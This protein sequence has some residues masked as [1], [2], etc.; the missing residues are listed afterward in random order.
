M[1]PILMSPT[2]DGVGASLFRL[3][4]GAGVSRKRGGGKGEEDVAVPQACKDLPGEDGLRALEE[5]PAIIPKGCTAAAAAAAAA[6]VF[7]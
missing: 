7:C 4:G 2:L 5:V 3:R 6:A 1:L